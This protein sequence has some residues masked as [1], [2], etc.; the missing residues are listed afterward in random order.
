ML[1]QWGDAWRVVE[2]ALADVERAGADVFARNVTIRQQ[3]LTVNDALLRSVAHVAYHTGQVVMMARS[4]AGDRWQSLSI[5]KGGSAAYAQ[6]P[7]KEKHP[8]G[9]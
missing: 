2:Q 9:N 8:D 6:N 7:T 4:F 1:E 5:P 3:P